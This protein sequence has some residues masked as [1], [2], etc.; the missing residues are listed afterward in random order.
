MTLQGLPMPFAI[1]FTIVACGIIGLV[2]G[3][4]VVKIGLNSLIVTLATG[5]VIYGLV[6]WYTAGTILFQGIRKNF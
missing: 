6:L 3:V 4:L 1:V 5:N 2:N